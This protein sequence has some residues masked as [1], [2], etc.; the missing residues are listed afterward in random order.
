MNKFFGDLHIINLEN[1]KFILLDIDGVI[2]DQCFDNYYWSNL[3][4]TEVA[5]ANNVSFN[6]A[7]AEVVS[8]G[9]ILEGTLPW[10][11][12]SHWEQFFN[13]DLI[14]PALE[15]M[16]LINFLPGAEKTL[17]ILSRKDINVILLTNCDSRLLNVKSDSV[18]FL[19]YVDACQSSTDLGFI[20]EEKGY[21]DLVFKKFKIDPAASIFLD[22]N[23]SIIKMAKNCGI[24]SAYH[25]LEPT[26]DKSVVYESNG[27]RYLKN[28]TK[29]I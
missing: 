17:E 16:S 2:L 12:L 26:S 28:I 21:W 29:L 5:K 4:P 24:E 14:K 9:K 1:Y 10:Y 3:V 15:H 20:K 13:V 23:K 6:D 22:D 7:K 25:V 19:Q 8:M 11:E 18:P 27:L